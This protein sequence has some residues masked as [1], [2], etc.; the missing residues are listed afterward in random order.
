MEMRNT[1]FLCAACK[2]PTMA[3]IRCPYC[4]YMVYCSVAHQR[5]HWQHEHKHHCQHI[6]TECRIAVDA[7]AIYAK[8]RKQDSIP[9]S[10]FK[11]LL[12]KHPHQY[13]SLRLY[14]RALLL[15]HTDNDDDALN[16]CQKWTSALNFL[17]AAEHHAMSGQLIRS[18]ESGL[19]LYRDILT[20]ALHIRDCDVHDHTEIGVL[21]TRYRE[22]QHRFK[23]KALISLNNAHK[24]PPDFV[25]WFATQFPSLNEHAYEFWFHVYPTL[26]KCGFDRW[27]VKRKAYTIQALF[28]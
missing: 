24:Y 14:G 6:Q 8:S 26:Q 4:K 9:V 5:Q 18:A 11:L 23:K 27:S 7:A 20:A 2:H 22:K 1:L 3:P 16:A 25:R 13:L 21:I 15:Q 10:D 17:L 19:H 12:L 28:S